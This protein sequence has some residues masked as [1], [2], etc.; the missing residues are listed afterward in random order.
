M[1]WFSILIWKTWSRRSLLSAGLAALLPLA[2]LEPAEAA[3]ITVDARALTTGRFSIGGATGLLPNDQVHTIAIAPGD[4]T[5]ESNLG[6]Q[7]FAFTVGADGL[8]SYDSSLDAFVDGTGTTALVVNGYSFTVDA[9][10]LTVGRYSIS[11]VSSLVPNDQVHTMAAIPGDYSFRSNLGAQNFA[12][13]LGSDGI[14]SYDSSL[15]A[16][17]DGRGTADLVVR[18]FP[19]TVDAL[20]LTVGRYSI[21]DV[22]SL[23]PNDQVHAM[24][25]LPGEYSFR[26]NLGAQNF[27]FTLGPDGIITY[28]VSLESYVE[29]NGTAALVVNGFSFTVDARP[30][31]VGRYFI[32]DASSHLPNDQVHTVTAIP[33]DYTFASNLGAQ[34]FAF[35]LGSEGI[36]TYD[37]S[38]ESYA[39]GNGTAALVVNG[40]SFTVD[41]RSLSARLFNVDDAAAYLQTETTQPL[42][43]IPG[44]YAFR[45]SYSQHAAGFSV[46]GDGMVS[47]PEASERFL[48]GGGTAE[49]VVDG[50]GIIVDARALGPGQFNIGGLAANLAADTVHCLTSIP[51]TYALYYGSQEFAFSVAAD[52]TVEYDPGP[53]IVIESAAACNLPPVA[54]AGPDQTGLVGVPAEFDAGASSDPDGTIVSYEWDFGDGGEPASGR[55][56][57]HVYESAGE[58]TAMLTVTDDSGDSASDTLTV[59]VQTPE[60]G[61]ADLGDV[62]EVLQ[63]SPDVPAGTS[64]SL[65]SSLDNAA[66]SI[67]SGNETAAVNKTKAFLNKVDAQRGKKLTEEQADQLTEGA[68]AVI[69]SVN[70]P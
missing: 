30:L 17:V 27:A 68:Q 3:T 20:S 5:F 44:D 69:D 11:D 24:A 9:L 62:V 34:K 19:F 16:Y 31:T 25:A 51:S 21:S 22:S 45:L 43:V 50:L 46:G 58:F 54:D 65:G 29:G 66:Q 52:G 12:F 4:Y 42:T 28:D 38:L 39:E 33:G 55:T 41:A 1:N 70:A 18:G 48:D 35:T 61:L 47:Y 8:I 36:I 59:A 63:E 26:S 23:V 49:L 67:A 2:A 64:T 32:G 53:G 57:S 40:F 60:E 10:S 13:R 37:V 15:D 56:A 14:I 7:D 6:R